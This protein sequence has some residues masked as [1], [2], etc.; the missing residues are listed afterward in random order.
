MALATYSD[1]QAAVAD[2]LER[3]DLAG[4]IPDFIT[5][6]ES[7]LNRMLRLRLMEGEAG[8]SS[9][10]G[11]RTIPLPAGFTEPVALWR[12]LDSGREPLRFVDPAAMTVSATAGQPRAW[13]ISGGAIAFERPCDQAYGFT[14]RMLSGLA[15]SA[16]APTNPVLAA[17]PDLYL[18]AALV[19][20]AP[21]LRDAD[22]LAMFS[23]RLDAALA[24]VSA[25]E[26]RSRA[27][28]T[29]EVEPPLAG[30]AAFDIRRG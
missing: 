4:R 3:G 5:L 28:A 6:A 19:E 14:L 8:L 18:F 11:A 17:Y 25:K 22:L 7:R 23:A 9:T 12:E 13:T 27:L 24:E 10:A 21:Y 29:L 26:A 20:A 15:L 1:L 2:W 30:P 16:A